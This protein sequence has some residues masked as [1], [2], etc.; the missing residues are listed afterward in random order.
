MGDETR[1]KV[2]IPENGQ[3]ALKIY[4][5]DEGEREY[6]EACNYLLR[7][8]NRVKVQEVLHRSFVTWAPPPTGKGW[9]YDFSAVFSALL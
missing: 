3:Y 6:K 8:Q 2:R 4:T 7:Q 5:R 1:V 9:D